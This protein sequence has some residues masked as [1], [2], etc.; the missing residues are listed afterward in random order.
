MAFGDHLSPDEHHPVRDGEAPERGRECA[1]LLDRVGVEADAL[2]LGQL[3]L[4][5]TL[6]LLCARAE[7]GELS[8]TT[9]RTR[10][11]LRLRVATVMAAQEAVAVQDERDV[12]VGAAQGQP[13]RATVQRR[14]DT[15]AVEE[16]DRFAAVLFD[17]SELGEQWRGQRI[18]RFAAEIDH[19]HGRQRAREPP[20]EIEPLE[21][22]PALG[23]RGCAAEDRDG[24]L[25][26]STLRRNGA[27]VVTRI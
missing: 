10:L 2:Q 8:G 1:R 21:R 11:R 19:S 5:L 4:E 23:A 12:A 15:P 6:Q 16:Q 25:E 3:R 13:T 14:R 27:R 24:V 18:P 9:G 20:A 17:R 26:R 7:P 22:P